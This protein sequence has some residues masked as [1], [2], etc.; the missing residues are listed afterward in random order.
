MSDKF[1]KSIRLLM[2]LARKMNILLFLLGIW[3]LCERRKKKKYIEVYNASV[4]KMIG[5]AEP[6]SRKLC[7]DKLN[8]SLV[9]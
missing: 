4:N 3:C 8:D 1:R 2:H 7:L 6:F 9:E 5:A